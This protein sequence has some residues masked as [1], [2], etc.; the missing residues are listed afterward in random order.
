MLVFCSAN[1]QVVIRKFD[2]TLKIGKVGYRA[3]CKNKNVEENELS[4]R[5]VGFENSAHEM[6]FF[7]RGRVVKAQIDD[8]NNDG[9]PDLILYVYTGPDTAYGVIYAFASQENKA[10]IPFGLPEVMLNGKINE[11]YK[12]H[13]QFTLLEGTLVQ[14]FPLYKPGDEKDKPTGGFRVI[15]YQ[16]ASGENARY[17]FNILRY[18]DSH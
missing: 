8:L 4:I 17:K 15:Q 13:D 18:Y 11:G 12:G 5:P 9:F 1:A 14:K 3:D 6:N 10:I 16:M 7:I 2:S